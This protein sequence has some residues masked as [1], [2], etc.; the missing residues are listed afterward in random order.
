MIK[1]K[2]IRLRKIQQ[3]A[4]DVKLKFGRSMS[5]FSFKVNYGILNRDKKFNIKPM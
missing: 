2:K 4:K 5:P 3:L 1:K